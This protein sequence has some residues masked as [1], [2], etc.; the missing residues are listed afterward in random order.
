[1]ELLAAQ[2]AAHDLAAACLRQR[3]HELDFLGHCQRR[4]PL[5]NMVHDFQF[6]VI[7]WLKASLYGHVRFHNFHVEGSG[8][9]TA[10]DS[11]TAGHSSRADST[12]KGP[13]RCPPVLMT[14]SSR[15]MNQ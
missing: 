8:F 4:Q 2:D 12:S 3:V 5:A 14:S 9:A 7:G 13:I 11:A 1:M 6:K 10:A 15:P